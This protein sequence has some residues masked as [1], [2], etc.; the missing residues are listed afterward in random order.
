MLQ[1]FLQPSVLASVSSLELIARTV[2]DGFVSG[3]HESPDFGFSQEFAEYRQYTPGDDLR[4]VDWNVY[5]RSE[6]MV[7]KR[8][9]GETNSPVM[10][11]L[12]AS[13]SMKM[14]CHS[15][16]KIDY[17]RYVA[18]SIMYLAAT[19][20]R[21]A[22]GLLLFDDEI[23][24]FVPPSTRQ[25]QLNR[26]LHALEN[27]EPGARTDFAK[28]FA[29]CMEF[30]RRRGLVVLVSDFL[31][32]PETIVQT[33]APLRYRGNEVILL[34]VLDPQ[35]VKP[36]FGEPVILIDMETGDSLEVTPEYA[37]MEYPEKMKRHLETLEQKAR[38]AGLDYH[39]MITDR[40]LDDTLRQYLAIRQGRF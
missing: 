4:H 19:R 22:C 26:L 9:R 15:V 11:L 35:E 29:H 31:S 13:N 12:D 36:K 1:R 33:V 18:A 7:L 25:G 21:D 16:S 37:Q 40:P 10:V 14:A 28:P 23:R 39:L 24:N 30:L 27:A 3:L 34:Q 6:R 2:V 8:F 38:G 17:A 20:Q 5:A 32:D